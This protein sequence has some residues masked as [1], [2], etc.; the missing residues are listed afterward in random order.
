MKSGPLVTANG[1]HTA[2]IDQSKASRSI[3]VNPFN[4]VNYLGRITLDPPSDIWVD[5]TKKPDLLVNLEGDKDAWAL[6][7]QNAFSYEWSDWETYWTGST[8]SSQ[9]WNRQDWAAGE[10]MRRV[11]ESTTTTTTS[12]QVKSGIKTQVVPSTITQSLGDRVIDISIIPYMRNRNILFTGSD[13]KPSTTLYPFFDNTSIEKYIA[14]SNKITLASS[15]LSYRTQSGNPE[16]VN[17]SNTA[18]S[19]TNGTAFIVRTSNTEAFIVSVEATSSLV[20]AT[21]NLVGTSTGTTYKING[22]EHNSGRVVSATANTV[23][24]ATH[25]EGANNIGSLV[26]QQISI[27]Y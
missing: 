4:V 17:V 21:M 25:A 12:N 1:T 18:T 26:G 14:R 24:L 23:V 19:T 13:F 10:R 22:Y 20:G 11:M 8:S 9:N 6:I 5:T 7:T 2:L 16:T 15:N 27:V 3:N